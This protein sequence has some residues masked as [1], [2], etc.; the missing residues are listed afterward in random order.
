MQGR[1]RAGEEHQAARKYGADTAAA[2]GRGLVRT[3]G[4]GGVVGPALPVG[5]QDARR[6]RQ[7][8]DSQTEARSLRSPEVKVRR[9]MA[10]GHP[11]K[12]FKHKGGGRGTWLGGRTTNRPRKVGR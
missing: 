1:R 6:L 12:G 8:V 11:E 4:Q 10:L 3:H 7:G 9:A 5:Q 2:C